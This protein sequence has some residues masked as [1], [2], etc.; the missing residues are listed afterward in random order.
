MYKETL[1]T[2]N[3]DEIK[4][5]IGMEAD[6][7]AEYAKDTPTGFKTII[8]YF[9][10]V[11]DGVKKKISPREGRIVV[12]DYLKKHGILDRKDKVSVALKPHHEWSAK[13]AD[14]EGQSEYSYVMEISVKG[15]AIKLKE[16]AN[17]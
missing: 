8:N 1:L 11:E 3:S 2:V 7:S 12:V 14:G 16:V 13:N 6:Y 15:H 17:V 9:F 10:T 5:V 4:E